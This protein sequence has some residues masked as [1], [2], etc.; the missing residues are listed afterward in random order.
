VVAFVPKITDFGLAKFL[1][2]GN[3]RTQTG[4][5]LG[6]PSY[7]APEQARGDHR[8]IG[9]ATDIY[10]LGAILHEMLTGRPPFVGNNELELMR[11]VLDDEPIAPSRLRSGL[12][13]DINTITLKCLQKLPAQRYASAQELAADLR[14]FLAGEPIAARPV[15]TPERA[16][17]WCR[18]RP[19]VAALLAAL[20][21]VFVG[22]FLVVT[23]LWR[24]SED[25]RT[26]AEKNYLDV[27]KA[28]AAEYQ[29]RKETDH[30]WEREGVAR[31]QAE[32]R[33]Y[34]SRIA[35]AQRELDASN[36]PG[37]MNLLVK[38]QRESPE[39]LGWEWGYLCGQCRCELLTVSGEALWYHAVAF[40]DGGKQLVAVGGNP[41]DLHDGEWKAWNAEDGKESFR[42]TTPAALERLTVSP[43]GRLAAATAADGTVILRQ[44]STGKELRRWQL[45][46]GCGALF[47]PDGMRLALYTAGEIQIIDL[48]DGR[49]QPGW[50]RPGEGARHMA[51]SSASGRV[52]LLAQDHRIEVR[53]AATG[54]VVWSLAHNCDF[55]RVALSP[56]GTLLAATDQVIVAVHQVGD[57]RPLYVL[58]PRDGQIYGLAFSPDGRFLATG[59]ADRTVRLWTARTGQEEAVYRGHQHAVR[60]VAFSPDG[61]RLASSGQDGTVRLWD[62]T[63]RPAGLRAGAAFGGE[64][65]G[66]FALAARPGEADPRLVCVDLD[67]GRLRELEVRTGAMTSSAGLDVVRNY[68]CPRYDVAFSSDGG[69]LAGPRH[70]DSRLVEVWESPS[71]KSLCRLEG[72]TTPIRCLSWGGP[73]LITVDGRTPREQARQGKWEP[74]RVRIWDTTAGKLLHELPAVFRGTESV[75]LSTDGRIAATA[76]RSVEVDG[77]SEPAGVHLWLVPTGRLLATLAHPKDSLLGLTFNANG[78]LLAGIDMEAD[79]VQVWDVASGKAALPPLQSPSFLTGLAFSPAN[80]TERLAG[81]GYDGVVY[82][83]EVATGQEVLALPGF[84]GRRP[85]DY[86]FSARVRFS[87]D[88][89]WLLANDWGRS[90]N[91]WEAIGPLPHGQDKERA[92]ARQ[93]LPAWHLLEAGRAAREENPAAVRFHLAHVTDAHLAPELHHR[94]AEAHRLLGDWDRAAADA[95][96][97]AQGLPDHPERWAEWACLC[98]VT[99][100]RD[101]C[102][103]ACRHLREHFAATA[104]P[105]ARR[106]ALRG[107]V[108]AEEGAANAAEWA[109]VLHWGEQK[110]SHPDQ[111]GLLRLHACALARAGRYAQAATILEQNLDPGPRG[112]PIPCCLMLAMVHHRLGHPEAARRWLDEAAEAMDT[113]SKAQP[114]G[115]D[116]TEWQTC[117]LWRMEAEKLLR[118]R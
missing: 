37:A 117:R 111:K 80:G 34:F 5:M 71:G 27:E 15:G 113:V 41:F 20:L 97:A 13:R 23:M 9:L 33:L 29:L 104:N 12:P 103:R 31:R 30:A 82:L 90:V 84:D 43:A 44:I 87:V 42:F 107:C 66:D 11:H 46:P 115:M 53:E 83:W 77:R 8:A 86:A 74:G 52:A 67:S 96:Q 99:G 65:L 17:R 19:M 2:S 68:I 50:S 48:I 54:R 59:G 60:G 1:D 116:W 92:A 108:L 110:D 45:K 98:L 51:A 10:G 69:R 79:A 6:T 112:G 32:R 72:H 7:M 38:C 49:P 109:V 28:R 102:R 94:R 40:A 70:D 61:A 101:G 78:R 16:W 58:R 75:A 100:D 85:D 89:H 95:G 64:W 21:L 18:R 63:R 36:V 76:S 39:L 26:A 81:I 62:L 106:S 114:W 14:R 24:V 56:D 57:D 118:G 93:R 3:C 35:L 91:L 105:D 73:H 22:G 88:G 47:L 55:V 4:Q 25:H